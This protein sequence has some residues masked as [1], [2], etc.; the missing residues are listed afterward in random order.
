MTKLCFSHLED[1]NILR[2]SSKMMFRLDH[3]RFGRKHVLFFSSRRCF[4][5]TRRDEKTLQKS[6]AFFLPPRELLQRPTR[7]N[8]DDR[9]RAKEERLEADGWRQSRRWVAGR[10]P[11]S[12]QSIRC[13]A[14]S[15]PS[16][17]FDFVFSPLLLLKNTPRARARP[18]IFCQTR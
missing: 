6:D 14:L 8:P 1:W 13:T 17:F 11:P 4:E 18:R 7:H 3:A 15:L 5:G 2:S 12:S 9:R 16:K 10:F